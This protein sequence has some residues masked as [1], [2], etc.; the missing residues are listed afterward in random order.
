MVFPIYYSSK[1]E[2]IPNFQTRFRC[3]YSQ[4]KLKHKLKLSVWQNSILE[5]DVTETASSYKN[6]AQLSVQLTSKRKNTAST[7]KEKIQKDT[8][9]S[10]V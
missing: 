7:K 8:I 3:I 5:V 1:R 2:D 6:D 4:R 10:H 9:L